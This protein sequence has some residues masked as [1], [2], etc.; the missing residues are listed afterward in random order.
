M[1]VSGPVTGFRAGLRPAAFCALTLQNLAPVLG[2]AA[3]KPYPTLVAMCPLSVARKS[4]VGNSR[5]APFDHS[6]KL[7]P[8]Y[9]STPFHLGSIDSM[10]RFASPWGL[11]AGGRAARS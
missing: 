3:A 9:R 8:Q 5:Y 10:Y 4:P 6:Q 1:S 11:S 2:T 7:P